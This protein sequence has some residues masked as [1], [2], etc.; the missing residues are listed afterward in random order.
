MAIEISKILLISFILILIAFLFDLIGFAT[1]NYITVDVGSVEIN[2]G[3]WKTCTTALGN[4]VCV[5]I[6]GTIEDKDWFRACR[7]M[8]IFGFI[9]LLVA[10]VLTGLKL[11][12]LRELKPIFFAAIGTT[13]AGAFFILVANS[14]YAANSDDVSGGNTSNYGFS[15]GLSLTAMCIAVASGI[16][17]IVDFVMGKSLKKVQSN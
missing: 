1:P 14:I 11:F 5:D 7:A 4:T 13:F 10:A 2:A 12:L 8:S 9:S 6:S 15:Y 3:L 16:I 17:M